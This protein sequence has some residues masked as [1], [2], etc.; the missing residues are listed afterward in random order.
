MKYE[1]KIKTENFGYSSFQE[2]YFPCF[3]EATGGSCGVWEIEIAIQWSGE[4]NFQDGRKENLGKSA[5]WQDW[6]TTVQ[7]GAREDKK[8]ICNEQIYLIF[9]DTKNYTEGL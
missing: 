2:I 6:R 9:E 4:G 8:K 5:L 7:S 3:L 1:N